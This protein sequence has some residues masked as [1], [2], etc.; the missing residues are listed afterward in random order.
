MSENFET[1]SQRAVAAMSA[2]LPYT[3]D[4]NT[5]C[6]SGHT[7]DSIG[8]E[9]WT[10]KPETLKS[11]PDV[12]QN[13]PP[14]RRASRAKKT[15][16][17][18][19]DFLQKWF[20]DWLT[21]TI[22][23]PLTGKG[24]RSPGDDGVRMVADAEMRFA[25][26]SVTQRLWTIRVGNGSD[27]FKAGAHMGLTPHDKERVATIRSGHTSNM[28]SLE[29]PGGGGACARLAP[30][31]LRLLGPVMVARADV[32]FD[33]S[34]KG[35]WDDLLAY[36]K[37]NAGKGAGAG[38]GEPT[39]TSSETGRTFKWGNRKGGGVSVKVYE[40]D[41]ERVANRKL[42]AAQADPDLVRVEF[43]FRPET[44]KKAAFAKLSPAQMLCTSR[45]VRRMVETLGRMIDYTD[46]EDVMAEQKVRDMPDA[47]TIRERAEYVIRQAARTT[48]MAA[49]AEMVARDFGGDWS[50]AEI[51]AGA[52]HE[53][54]TDMIAQELARLGTAHDF[55]ARHGLDEV[56][57]HEERAAGM[58]WELHAYLERQSQETA[59]SQVRLADALADAQAGS[60]V[61]SS[62]SNVVRFFGS[63]L[64]GA[65]AGSL[66]GRANSEAV[67]SDTGRVA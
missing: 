17:R 35:L 22:P 51:D 67:R 53:A 33:W 37:A 58:V 9:G 10:A 30:S 29:I 54:A 20:L 2:R 3:P 15:T 61:E 27:G 59:E 5:G 63:G 48:I 16:D 4:G 32:S 60:G 12:P 66:A 62:S 31:A 65:A 28:P 13:T 46:K 40:K 18:M 44:K 6:I 43:T 36:A 55:V 39:V 41:L 42:D 34:Q 38:M 24:V 49:A 64:D 21:V 50:A 26:W 1:L 8:N 11:A 56:R 19:S 57:T 52:L 47:T 7:S 23:N 14:S 45:W 25:I